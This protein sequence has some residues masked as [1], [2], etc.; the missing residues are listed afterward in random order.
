VKA[1]AQKIAS[2]D[3]AVAKGL[4]RHV[5][6][7]LS[8]LS[9]TTLEIQDRVVGA[10]EKNDGKLGPVFEA[11]FSSETYACEKRE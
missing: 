1:L 4:A 10:Y 9:S 8:N 2:S 5:P 6:R 7:A 11:Y 3:R